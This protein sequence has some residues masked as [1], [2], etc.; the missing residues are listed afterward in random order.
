MLLESSKEE[1]LK[2]KSLNFI[3]FVPGVTQESAS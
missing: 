3:T 1:A 2:A